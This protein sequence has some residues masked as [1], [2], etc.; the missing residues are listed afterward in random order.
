[1]YKKI[2]ER[3]IYGIV[4]TDEKGKIIDVNE[5]FCKLLGYTK[6]E[7]LG[8]YTKEFRL[9]KYFKMDKKILK[10]LKERGK[11]PLYE[12]Y[13]KKKDGSVIPL[14]IT[15]FR[16]NNIYVGFIREI[17]EIKK[18]QK[19]LIAERARLNA[20]IKAMGDG[21]SITNSNY[22]IEFMNDVL[23]KE[24]GNKIGEHCYK[25]FHA[26]DKPCS[27]C[28]LHDVI[29]KGI[30]LKR[31]R[32]FKN[33]KTYM[34]TSTPLKNPDGSVSK[35]S[36]L[37]DV[38]KMKER[39]KELEEFYEMAVDR[40]LRMIELKKEIERLKE[41]LACFKTQKPLKGRKK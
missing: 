3:A 26:R 38:T 34:I 35:L 11:I 9:K 15:A 4:V 21:L 41:E 39:L 6:E 23:I 36:I 27:D 22:V 18:L 13:A 19:E 16:I 8:R 2:F 20:I 1:M 12:T 40:E 29:E 31:E 17:S 25:I 24:F 33:G 32:T 5:S 37:K 28:R 14:E 10:L 30:T 7:I